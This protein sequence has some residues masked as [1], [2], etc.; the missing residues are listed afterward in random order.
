VPEKDGNQWSL[1][2]GKTIQEG[3]CGFGDTPE[4]AV[5]DFEKAMSATSQ[6]GQ[7]EAAN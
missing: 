2:W 4:A 1:L 3:V 6:E 5:W 7:H